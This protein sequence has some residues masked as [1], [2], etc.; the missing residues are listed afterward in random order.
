MNWMVSAVCAPPVD[1]EDEDVGGGP[2]RRI[3]HGVRA[4]GTRV[5]ANGGIGGVL[6]AQAVGGG[7]CYLA[8]QYRQASM[9]LEYLLLSYPISDCSSA[10]S[11]LMWAEDRGGP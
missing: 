1:F 4:G 11:K 3:F 5:R 7:R 8:G 10:I 9:V 6:V 2:V